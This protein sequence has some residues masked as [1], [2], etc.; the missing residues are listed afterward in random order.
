MA[1]G[2]GGV[3]YESSIQPDD[4]ISKGQIPTRVE[5]DKVQSG[6]ETAETQAQ[7]LEDYKSGM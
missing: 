7:H 4:Q 5:H 6:P 3:T 2:G 1:G